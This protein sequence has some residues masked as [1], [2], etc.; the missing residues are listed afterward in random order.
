[1]KNCSAILKSFAKMF[2][3]LF[4]EED[5]MRRWKVMRDSYVKYLNSLKKASGASGETIKKPAF[6]DS[7]QFL[8]STIR[9]RK[10]ATHSMDHFNECSE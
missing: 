5:C 6:A 4:T 7:L 9:H 8:S 2:D 3:L 10:Y 1:M